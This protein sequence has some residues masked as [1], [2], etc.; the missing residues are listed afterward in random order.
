MFVESFESADE[1]PAV[2]QDDLH[3]VIY[4]LEH[5][6][7]LADRHFRRFSVEN[8]SGNYDDRFGLKIIR[9]RR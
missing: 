7:V 9:R 1:R 6:V 8:N 4:M 5:L 3:P 2:L